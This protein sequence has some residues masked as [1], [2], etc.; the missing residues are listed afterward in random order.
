MWTN[1]YDRCDVDADGDDNVENEKLGRRLS[2]LAKSLDV[3]L[4]SVI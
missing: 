1:D 2:M 3:V 4:I